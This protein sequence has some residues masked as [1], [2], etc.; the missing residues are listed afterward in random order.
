M[1]LNDRVDK[2]MSW[3]TDEER[4]ANLIFA[5]FEEPDKTAHRTGIESKD[6]KDQIINTDNAVKYL[7][8][9]NYI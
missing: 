8:F 4:P 6:I 2:I 1:P 7:K 9:M 3:I 5:Y